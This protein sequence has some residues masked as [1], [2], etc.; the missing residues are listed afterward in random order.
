[1]IQIKVIVTI[2]GW[3][4]SAVRTCWE[5]HSFMSGAGWEKAFSKR[6]LAGNFVKI[7]SASWL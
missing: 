3:Q 4:N 6:F 2:P 5:N 7:S 1:M